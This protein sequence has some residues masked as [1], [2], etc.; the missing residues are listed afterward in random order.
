L[1]AK[2]KEEKKKQLQFD[3]DVEE[4]NSHPKSAEISDEEADF[5]D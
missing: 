1:T 3:I 5:A 4:N 2:K